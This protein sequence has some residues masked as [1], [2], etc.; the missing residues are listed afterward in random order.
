VSGATASVAIATRFVADAP[1]NA[2]RVVDGDGFTV[3]NRLLD[4]GRDALFFDTPGGMVNRRELRPGHRIESGW[5]TRE[6]FDA[7]KRERWPHLAHMV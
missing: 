7:E 2:V 6:A 1:D 5:L 4:D 3:Y